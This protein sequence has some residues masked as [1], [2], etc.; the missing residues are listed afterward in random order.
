MSFFADTPAFSGAVSGVPVKYTF[1]NVS[2]FLP[3]SSRMYPQGR[4]TVF[5][6]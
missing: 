3:Q 1:W 2:V 6:R 4:T 5:F